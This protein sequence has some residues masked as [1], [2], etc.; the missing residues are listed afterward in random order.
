M[1]KTSLIDFPGLVAATVFYS[2][3]NLRCP[4][5]HNPEL[6]CGSIPDDF[7]P[8]EDVIDFLSRRRAVLGGVCISGGEPTLHADLPWMVER[9]R[10]LGLSVKVDTNGLLPQAL[11]RAKPDYVAVDLKTSPQRYGEL[12]LQTDGSS[13]FGAI[14]RT[15]SSLRASGAVYEFRTTV[16]PELVGPAEASA[17]MMELLPGERWYLQRFRPDVVLDPSYASLRPPSAETLERIWSEAVD[18]GIQCEIRG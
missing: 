16:V 15:M 4:F 9:I 5:C 1:R 7:I 14:R 2:G 10:E 3:C 11:Q 18:R 6:A 8:A 17:I 12:S 13:L